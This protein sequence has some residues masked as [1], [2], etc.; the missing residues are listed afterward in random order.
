MLDFLK[1]LF[2]WIWKKIL[3]V[4]LPVVGWTIWFWENAVAIWNDAWSWIFSSIKWYFQDFYLWLFGKITE[5]MTSFFSGNDFVV[6]VVGFADST[7]TAMN[8]FIPL[9]E[10]CACA[11]LIVTTMISVFIIRIILKAVPTIW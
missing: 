7:F 1:D 8:V 9:N 4:F 3:Y 2:V 10:T 6:S 5:L 11:T